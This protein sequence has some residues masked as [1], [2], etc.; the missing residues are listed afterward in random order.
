M[1]NLY[2]VIK[3][4]PQSAEAKTVQDTIRTALQGVAD[5]IFT[6]TDEAHFTETYNRILREQESGYL[7]AVS[8]E[9]QFPEKYF[10][11]LL[12][13]LKKKN[14][15]NPAA[16]AYGTGLKI[17]PWMGKEFPN[18]MFPE[19]GSLNIG[20]FTDVL[21]GTVVNLSC[22]KGS[23]LNEAFPFEKE[24]DLLLRLKLDY[25]VLVD[26]HQEYR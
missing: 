10:R 6:V 20:L 18:K 19:Q 22:T 23:L 11:S 12:N 24:A 21:W 17:F 7:T 5:C 2:V 16:C 8:E 13:G 9:D 15:K 14:K 26:V 25:S 4:A 1:D 3:G